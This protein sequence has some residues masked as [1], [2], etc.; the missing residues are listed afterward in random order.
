MCHRLSGPPTGDV[1]TEGTFSP[2]VV[3]LPTRRSTVPA[4]SVALALLLAWW[5]GVT[6]LD[7]ALASALPY[8]RYETA[9]LLYPDVYYPGLP[10]WILASVQPFSAGVWAAL[11]GWMLLLS[12]AVGVGSARYADRRGRSPVRVAAAVVVAAFVV[13]TVAEAVASLL[14]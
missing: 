11:G 7:G 1:N 9:A 10:G 4:S 12:I 5:V 3:A 2:G 6:A 8:R 14:A 13:A